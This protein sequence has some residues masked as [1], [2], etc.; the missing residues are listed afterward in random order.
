MNVFELSLSLGCTVCVFQIEIKNI[1]FKTAR[2]VEREKH[3]KFVEKKS[4]HTRS[5]K[6][7]LE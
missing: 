6:K 3:T 5:E 4:T 2:K 7:I 1:K